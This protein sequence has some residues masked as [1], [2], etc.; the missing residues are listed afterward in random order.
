MDKYDPA[1]IDRA[2]RRSVMKK[3]PFYAR[4]LQSNDLGKGKSMDARSMQSDV[5]QAVPMPE[6][7]TYRQYLMEKEAGDPNAR[8]LSFQEWKKL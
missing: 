7:N 5:G 3:D 1:E 2:V 8:N 4:S 6:I